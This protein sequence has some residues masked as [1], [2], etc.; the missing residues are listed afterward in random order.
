MHFHRYRQ[1]QPQVGGFDCGLFSLAF[2]SVLAACGH[3]SAYS[4]DQRRMRPH[5]QSCLMANTFLPFPVLRLGRENKN[6]VHCDCRMP[7]MGD[8]MIQCSTC[9]KWFHLDLCVD[10]RDGNLKNDWFCKSCF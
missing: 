1:C 9:L 7:N 2:A 3:P 5:L 8:P 4:F 6:K 10:I